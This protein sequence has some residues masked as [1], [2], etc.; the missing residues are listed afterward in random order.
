MVGS[1]LGSNKFKTVTVALET[2]NE[3]WEMTVGYESTSNKTK[4]L[5][6]QVFRILY[7][8]F[9]L[10]AVCLKRKFTRKEI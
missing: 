10:F 8:C 7:A 4:V 3:G 9:V 2:T 5:S 1:Q 6:S